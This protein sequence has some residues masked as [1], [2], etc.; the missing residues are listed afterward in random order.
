MTT[1]FPEKSFRPKF[2]V[3]ALM[4]AGSAEESDLARTAERCDYMMQRH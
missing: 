1:P 3:V 4:S 2:A